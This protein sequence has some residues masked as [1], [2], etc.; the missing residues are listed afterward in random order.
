MPFDS[1]SVGRALIGMA[2][3]EPKIGCLDGGGTPLH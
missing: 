3:Y 1:T 2:G